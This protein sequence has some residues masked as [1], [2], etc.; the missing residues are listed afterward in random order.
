MIKRVGCAGFGSATARFMRYVDGCGLLSAIELPQRELMGSRASQVDVDVLALGWH[1]PELVAHV[2]AAIRTAHGRPV[3]VV[4]RESDEQ[5]MYTYSV[6]GA[7]AVLN[8]RSPP[9]Q[10]VAA[11]LLASAGMRI[12]PATSQLPA[13]GLSSRENEVLALLQTEMTTRAIARSLGVHV[14]TVRSQTKSVYRKLGVRRRDD[15]RGPNLGQHVSGSRAS[16]VGESSP[17]ELDDVGCA[18]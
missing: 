14:E 2:N 16:I 12:R 6:L 15:L 9:V 3:V 4:L 1:L 13:V 18:D 17:W 5:Q 8:A 11:V 7:A 10:I